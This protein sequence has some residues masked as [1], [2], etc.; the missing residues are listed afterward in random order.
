MTTSEQTASAFTPTVLVE[1]GVSVSVAGDV[2]S[3]AFQE[4][5]L[6]VAREQ[7]CGAIH[8]TAAL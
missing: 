5:L 4:S 6:L 8:P 7:L 2:S 1:S 3:S